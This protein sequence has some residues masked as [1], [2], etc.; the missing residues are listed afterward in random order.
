MRFRKQ[1]IFFQLTLRIP[2][3]TSSRGVNLS[4]PRRSFRLAASVGRQAR[5]RCR[6]CFPSRPC[7]RIGA[8]TSFVAAR[9][10]G[11]LPLFRGLGQQL[12]RRTVRVPVAVLDLQDSPSI[13]NCNRYLLQR[14]TIYFKRELPPDRWRLLIHGGKTPTLRY[15]RIERYQSALARVRPLS[16]GLPD[17]VQAGRIPAMP[18][19]GKDID[20]FFA[21]RLKGSSTVRERGIDELMQLQKAGHPDR[22]PGWRSFGP[23]ISRA[24]RARLACLGAGRLR[25]GLLSP[26]RSRICR[27]RSAHQPA[28]H[29]APRASL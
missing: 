29:R 25:M 9:F 14:S 21:G 3:S 13:L 11:H 15:R 5:S 8:D 12:L 1:Q 24:L 28:D 4:R 20:V 10:E 6:P 17:H 16:L 23:G 18:P 2:N 27:V 19:G 26:L 7:R 22:H